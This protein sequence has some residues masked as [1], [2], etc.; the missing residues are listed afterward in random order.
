ME[1]QC[2]RVI[3]QR[4]GFALVVVGLLDIA[5]MIYCIIHKISYSSSLNLFAVIAGILL[6]RGSLRTAEGVRWFGTFFLSGCVAMLFAWP[7]IEP[8]NLALTTMRLNPGFF[9]AGAATTVV[10]VAWLYWTV[11]ELGSEPVQAAI[12]AAGV[13]HRD[14]RFPIILGVLMVVGLGVSLHVIF[15]GKSAKR[16]ILVAANQVGPGYQLHIQSLH[17]SNYGSKESVTGVVTAWK[18]NEI[19][20]IP[21]HWENPN[22]D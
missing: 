3:L 10:F 12:N 2:H 1:R 21:I 13:K 6:I 19:R 11:R 20:E 18:D 14:M 7:A 22:S 4:V 5:W 15:D 9:L 16:A 17:I 8:V